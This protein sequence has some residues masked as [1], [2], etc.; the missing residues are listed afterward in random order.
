MARFVGFRWTPMDRQ[1]GQAAR[2]LASRLGPGWWTLLDWRGVLIMAHEAPGRSVFLLERGAG[3]VFGEV[4]DGDEPDHSTLDDLDAAVASFVQRRWGAYVAVLVD[5]GYDRVHVLRDP[6]GAH[7][8]F[9]TELGG[10]H[11]FFSDARDF[12][13]LAPDTEPDLSFVRAFLTYPKVAARRTG[14]LGVDEVFPGECVTLSRTSKSNEMIWRPG[15]VGRVG[16]INHFAEAAGSIRR[17]AD[18]CVRAWVKKHSRIAH[19]LSGG[20]DSAVV[21]GLLVKAAPAEAIVCVNEYWAEAPEGDERKQAGAVAEANGVELIE[22]AMAPDQV[23]YEL[24]LDAPLTV[25]PTL[26]L[27]S[28]ADPA[29]GAAYAD[30][31]CDLLT[32]GQGGDHVFHRSRTPWIAADAVRDALPAQM[33][34]SIALDTARLTGRSVWAILGAMAAA[35]VLHGR[36]PPAT[37]SSVM[38]VLGEAPPDEALG[39]HAWLEGIAGSPPARALRRW[40]LLDAL[41]YHDLSILNANVLAAPVLLSQPIVEACL[42]TPPYI[43]TQGGR[44]RALARAAFT[45]IVPAPVIARSAKGETTRYFAAI[46]AA[47]RDWIVETLAGGELVRLGVADR[48][49]MGRALCRDWRQ[50]GMAADGLYSLIA[51]EVWLRN[52]RRERARALAQ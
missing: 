43:M 13:A 35:G 28:F 5:R 33:C 8:C 38:G 34:L 30:L 14:L 26:A 7:P 32:S 22:L 29:A 4:F 46:L 19:R 31:G 2:A 6:S 27:L 21:L 50:D 51:A 41:G 42:R 40:Q 9:L 20:F 39:L 17:T 48:G 47:N 49:A 44:E 11:V 16:Q 10:V 25:K 45:D 36:P 15:D 52:L 23:K 24:T 37:R 3:V 1:K 12:I 18:T